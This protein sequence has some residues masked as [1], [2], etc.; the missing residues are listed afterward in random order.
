LSNQRR[1]N[2]ATAKSPSAV[3]FIHGAWHWGGCFQKVAD[4]LAISGIPIAT[5]D[6]ASHGYSEV[7]VDEIQTLDDYVAPVAKLL[8]ASET[9]VTLV[10]HSLGGA[11]IGYL[12]LRYPK[13]I[14]KLIY[15]TA[16]LPAP[17][18]TVSDIIDTYAEE[19]AAAEAFRVV[20]FVSTGI[21]LD[22]AKPDLVRAA[23]YADCSDQDVLIANKNVIAINTGVPYAWR[24]PPHEYSEIAR[25]FIRCTADRALPIG[26]QD[27]MI[28]KASN[29]KVLSLESSH[30][31]FFSKP[32]QLARL[33]LPEL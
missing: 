5:P 31:P 19:R 2:H 11:L 15:L 28:K 7:R 20:A 8:A 21:K 13:K 23:F 17:G 9:P 24:A 32:D 3:I 4:L 14:K 18:E 25:V 22:L 12:A 30:S 27:A 10:G 29:L 1:S 26:I 16:F 6:L 33:I